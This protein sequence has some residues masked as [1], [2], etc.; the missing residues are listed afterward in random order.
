MLKNFMSVV[1]SDDVQRNKAYKNLND[2]LERNKENSNFEYNDLF[3]FCEV[4]MLFVQN[5]NQEEQVDGL[6][7]TQLFCQ[8]LAT[9]LLCYSK[10]SKQII[11]KLPLLMRFHFFVFL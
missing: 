4:I 5:E 2:Y 3:K 11:I 1:C 9:Q 10:K 6:I 8:N 7:V